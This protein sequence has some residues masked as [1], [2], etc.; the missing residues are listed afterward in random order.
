MVHQNKHQYVNGGESK[1]E[2][3]NEWKW[4]WRDKVIKSALEDKH[5]RTEWSL[6]LW[7]V[8]HCSVM[9]WAESH[10]YVVCLGVSS[11]SGNHKCQKTSKLV[12]CVMSF[13]ID[14]C[15]TISSA[16]FIY[17]WVFKHNYYKDDH[18]WRWVCGKWPK[19]KY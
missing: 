3:M 18:M 17:F 5:H 13:Y 1:W 10:F 12:F 16:E 8:L 6:H 7:W 11:I 9:F 14:F 4:N 2:L 19:P 15:N